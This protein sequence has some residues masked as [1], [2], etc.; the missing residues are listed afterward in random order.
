VYMIND[1]QEERETQMIRITFETS[2]D[3]TA[4]IKWFDV[5]H[6]NK[7]MTIDPVEGAWAVE[8]KA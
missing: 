6:P 1:D 3:F 8:F 2:A 7:S 5:T 4:F